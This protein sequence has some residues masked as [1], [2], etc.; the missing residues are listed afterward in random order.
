LFE[1]KKKNA[2][3]KTPNTQTPTQQQKKRGK[4]TNFFLR[5]V[6]LSARKG[7]TATFFLFCGLTTATQK[8]QKNKKNN[9][10]V[11]TPLRLHKRKQK[12]KTNKKETLP[13]HPP[14]RLT[15]SK[16]NTKEQKK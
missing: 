15:V 4:K 13:P 8:I 14:Q 10:D 7:R 16:K 12:N 3:K 2:E 1:N 9:T 11:P 5:L 6:S